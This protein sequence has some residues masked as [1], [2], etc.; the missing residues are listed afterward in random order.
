MPYLFVHDGYP[1]A[2][3]YGDNYIWYD[4]RDPDSVE[5]AVEIARERMQKRGESTHRLRPLPRLRRRHVDAAV[6]PPRRRVSA[7]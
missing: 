6:S 4:A 1:E 7:R 3:D 5:R 2:E